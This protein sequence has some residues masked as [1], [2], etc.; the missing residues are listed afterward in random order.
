M[1]LLPQEL[2]DP[3]E[4]LALREHPAWLDPQEPREIRVAKDPLVLI[5][6]AL[7]T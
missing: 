3:L 6:T 1:D 4:A 5:W 7:S 2:L